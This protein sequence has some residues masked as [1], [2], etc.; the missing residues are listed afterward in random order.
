[1]VKAYEKRGTPAEFKKEVWML[2]TFLGRYA[3]QPLPVLRK[4][5]LID[6]HL[7]AEC[8]GELLREENGPS[9]ND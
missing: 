8:T 2:F 9:G 6:L 5:P 4:M 3:H 1:M 7:M